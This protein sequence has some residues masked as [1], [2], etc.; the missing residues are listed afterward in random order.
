MVWTRFMDMHSGGGQK[1]SWP[2]IYIEAPKE[3]AIAIFFYRFGRNPL[4]ITCTCCG[5]DYS[6]GERKGP[7]EQV[8]RFERGCEYNDKT[9]QYEERPGRF[10]TYVPLKPFLKTVEVIRAKDIKPEERKASVPQQGYIWME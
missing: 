6:I 3:E 10:E 8:T 2:Y 9:N 1:L 5:E 7:L 4:R